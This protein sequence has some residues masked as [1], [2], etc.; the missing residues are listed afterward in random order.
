MAYKDLREFITRLEREGQLK[1]VSTDVDVDLEITEITDRVS[2]VGGPALLFEKPRSRKD[3]KSYGMP[4]LI[5]TLGSRRRLE[6]A[7]EVNSVEDVARRI[8]ELL[9]MRPPE[10]LF[11]KMKGAI[12]ERLRGEEEQDETE[13]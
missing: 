5:N 10:G 2:K 9:E 11:D 6:L 3:G 12:E 8:D 1:R 7:L 4:I 13:E